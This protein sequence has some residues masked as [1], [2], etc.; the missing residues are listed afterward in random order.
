M[1]CVRVCVCDYLFEMFAKWYPQASSLVSKH[2]TGHQAIEEGWAGKRNAEIEAKEPPVLGILI[3]LE[4]FDNVTQKSVLFSPLS[5]YLKHISHY[6]KV[7]EQTIFFLK[8]WQHCIKMKYLIRYHIL[9]SNKKK[10]CC[11]FIL[12]SVIYLSIRSCLSNMCLVISQY[13]CLCLNICP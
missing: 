9:Q 2:F 4:N 12:G 1:V 11:W 7:N 13:W 10:F 8:I 6:R 5:I 3:D